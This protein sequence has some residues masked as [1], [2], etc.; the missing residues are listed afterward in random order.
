MELKFERV[1]QPFMLLH[2]NRY[3][4]RA[5]EREEDVERGGELI[6][7]GVKSMWRQTAPILR[8]T[9]HGAL[10]RILMRDDLRYSCTAKA[11]YRT[12]S[13]NTCCSTGT[14]GWRAC[15][16]QQPGCCRQAPLV[17]LLLSCLLAVFCQL[18]HLLCC[19]I[20]CTALAWPLP[21]PCKHCFP[22][23]LPQGCPGVCGRGGAALAERSGRAARAGDDGGPV[24]ADGGAGGKR[25]GRGGAQHR[26]SAGERLEQ[27]EAAVSL[28]PP[29]CLRHW[30]CA[31]DCGNTGLHVVACAP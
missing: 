23:R 12:A 24:A 15:M 29:A 17:H 19:C 22:L 20:L 4:G 26:G 25:G 21:S 18:L 11:L 31:L 30:L 2:V 8:T 5:F 10:E 13:A 6:C 27:A 28:K 9:L 3:A 16:P 14:R 1:C 7:K